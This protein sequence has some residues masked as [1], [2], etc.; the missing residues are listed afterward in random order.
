VLSLKGSPG[1]ARRLLTLKE[2]AA[3]LGVSTASIRRL[4]GAGKL[5]AVRIQRRIQIDT[6]DLDRLIEHFKEH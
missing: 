1:Q 2:A 6:R 4:I 3:L 5:P